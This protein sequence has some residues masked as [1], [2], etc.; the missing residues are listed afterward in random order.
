MA[1]LWNSF[2]AQI[3][4]IRSRASFS[5]E[6]NRFLGATSSAASTF[7]NDFF[8]S[9]VNAQ[10]CHVVKKKKKIGNE[11]DHGEMRGWFS[12]SVLYRFIP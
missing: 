8:V 3:P 9:A 5:R 12:E 6:V 10:L 7:V 1:Q 2:P 11:N 4:A